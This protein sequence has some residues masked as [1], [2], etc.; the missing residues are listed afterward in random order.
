M[1]YMYVLNWISTCINYI[2]YNFLM[3]LMAWIL[4]IYLCQLLI[5]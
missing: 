4:I 1:L 5:N 3:S 2:N